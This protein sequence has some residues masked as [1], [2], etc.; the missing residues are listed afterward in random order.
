[1]KKGNSPIKTWALRC[2]YLCLMLAGVAHGQMLT[3]SGSQLTDASGNPISNATISFAPV[4]TN[5]TPASFRKGTT[6][7]QAVVTPVTATV[8]SGAFSLQVVDTS[9]TI[10]ANMCYAVTVTDNVTGNQLL[11]SGYGCVQPTSAGAVWCPVS[12]GVATCNFDAYQP[13]L[14]ALVQTEPGPPGPT[15]PQGPLGPSGSY[16]S[17]WGIVYAAAYNSFASIEEACA[18][19]GLPACEVLVTSQQTFTLTANHTTPVGMYIAF[20]PPGQ[21]TVNGPYTLTIGSGVV[22]AP[23]TAQIFAGTALVNGLLEDHPEWFPQGTGNEAGYL[24]S[25]AVNALSANGGT[26]HLGIGNYRSGYDTPGAVTATLSGVVI[27]SGGT[28]TGTAPTVTFSAPGTGGTVATGV[29][30][31]NAGGTAVVGVTITNPGLYEA[32]TTGPPSVTFSSGGATATVTTNVTSPG[33]LLTPNVTIAG[34]QEGIINYPTAIVGG[35]RIMGPFYLFASNFHGHDFCVDVGSNVVATWYGSSADID[36][37]SQNNPGQLASSQVENFRLER[38][39]S[40]VNNWT[41]PNHAMLIEDVDNF[42]GSQLTMAG[43]THG[44]VLKT[45]NSSADGITS[46]EHASDGVYLKSDAYANMHDTQVSNVSTYEDG[47]GVIIGAATFVGAR[48]SVNGVTCPAS[49]P[50]CVWGQNGALELREL[51]ISNVESEGNQAIQIDPGL[52]TTTISNVNSEYSSTNPIVLASNTVLDGFS[53]AG[54]ESKPIVVESGA[55]NVEISNGLIYGSGTVDGNGIENSGT[56]TTISNVTFIGPMPGY[57]VENLAGTTYT[58]GL[59]FSPGCGEGPYGGTGI[60]V[61]T[62]PTNPVTVTG[63]AG[64]VTNVAPCT[65]YTNTNKFGCYT[66]QGGTFTTGP[67]FS[68]YW[69]P[70]PDYAPRNCSFTQISGPSFVGVKPVVPGLT[71]SVGVQVANSIAGV[72]FS[73]TYSCSAP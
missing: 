21:W 29:A 48:V 41:A 64:G 3:V 32:S 65:G 42:H 52:S 56:L 63:W 47:Y 61:D 33:I 8:T 10:P 28:Y 2:V 39:C 68:I 13:N 49:T 9:Q 40:L 71:S 50:V 59:V 24:I 5:G 30:V 20:D 44:L 66:V 27:T 34:T 51:S 46:F 62:Y 36:A 7:G 58:H 45:T 6:G 23:P 4:L 60:V 12:G 73:F 25:S 37:F 57:C 38:V 67:I 1:M 16:G 22:Q 17:A 19:T 15:G 14:A 69:T 55:V 53:I 31:L 11:G 18:A 26:V 70:Y 35:S 43:G 72:T 54:G